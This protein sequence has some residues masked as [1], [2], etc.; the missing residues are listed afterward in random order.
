MTIPLILFVIVFLPMILEAAR[1]NANDRGLRAAG[2]VEAPGDV[3][4][5]MALAYP[6]FF[7][8]MIGEAWVRH[9]SADTLFLLGAAIFV[10]A[11]GLKY[12]AIAT[13]GRRW[14]FRVLVP[15]GSSR[16]ITGPYV[17]LDHPNYVAVAG[18]VAGVALMAGA[19]VTGPIAFVGFVL[20]ML[21]RIRIEERALGMP[22][23]STGKR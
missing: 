16:T 7:L 14:T 23:R 19:L 20:L 18:E 4:A 11:K 2:A 1:S 22:V 12:W 10:L 5:V 21:R 8:A 9:R 6:G 17:F 3:H 15:P 13:L